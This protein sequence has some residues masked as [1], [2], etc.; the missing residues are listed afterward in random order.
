MMN[1][2]TQITSKALNDMKAIYNYITEQLLAP[3]AAMEQYNRIAD[4]I[5]SLN[6]L[7]E[8]IKIMDSEPEHSMELRRM[9]V[10]NYS[11]FYIIQD[12]LV[13][14]TRVLYSASDVSKRLLE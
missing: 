13:I 14:V 8:R 5:E 1:Y 10:D 2:M 9:S 6:V 7:P 3:E 12:E 4:A 11:I